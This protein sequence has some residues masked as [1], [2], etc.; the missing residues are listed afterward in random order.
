MGETHSR[1]ADADRDRA[2]L[3]PV[4][5]E[6]NEENEDN[7]NEDVTPDAVD[8]Q[9][10]DELEHEGIPNG[11]DVSG[12][13]LLPSEPDVE[14]DDIDAISMAESLPNLQRAATRLLDFFASSFSSPSRIAELA[15]QLANPNSSQT[16]K[17]Q[18]LN[19]H[20][21]S[22]R[23]YFGSD[24]YIPVERIAAIFP[25][26]DFSSKTWRVDGI[27]YK[28]NCAQLALEILTRIQMTPDALESLY[29]LEGQF[30]LP[31]VK[32][33][34][35]DILDGVGK[36]DLRRP[37]FDLALDIRTQWLKIRLVAEQDAK[38][39]PDTILNGVFFNESLESQSAA[40]TGS[41]LRGFNLAGFFQDEDGNLP[42]KYVE[43]VQE[44]IHEIRGCFKNGQVDFDALEERFPWE[45]FIFT[46]AKWIRSRNEELN[47]HL[48]QQ[49]SVD[50]IADELEKA[51]T[52]SN[53]EDAKEGAVPT[54]QEERAGQGRPG[55]LPA[56]DIKERRGPGSGK[57]FSDMNSI[58]A[59]TR[60]QQQLNPKN[61]STKASEFA[62]RLSKLVSN[63][64]GRPSLP[65]T[66]VSR[67]PA[68]RPRQQVSDSPGPGL[69]S[70]DIDEP[71][72]Q[73]SQQRR[74]TLDPPG[75]A[76]ATNQ[77]LSLPSQSALRGRQPG[78]F[79]DRQ[80][81]A[82]RVSPIDSQRLSSGGVS[83]SRK[84]TRDAFDALSEDDEDE[85]GEFES[86]SRRIDVQ[87]RRGQKPAQ[88][89][90][91]A[92]YDNAGND[93]EVS[94]ARRRQTTG[95]LVHRNEEQPAERAGPPAPHP[96]P[97]STPQR[98]PQTRRP[99]TKEED[100][101][102]ISLITKHGTSWAEIKSQDEN[103]EVPKLRNR[104]QGNLKDRARNLV[105]I[106]LK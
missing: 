21:A 44:R 33:L 30:P 3:A 104:D 22:Q 7:A 80:V 39:D 12:D 62:P 40:D 9:L 32:T 35:G 49:P 69:D 106:M 94:F 78:T 103:S 101:Q 34:A 59:F 87:D 89:A 6:D 2:D 100:E 99:W 37:T 105:M 28:S 54:S 43:D 19:T 48:E 63:T 77:R 60:L 41:R 70:G 90:K 97:Q 5:E 26:I 13:T 53:P 45:E 66:P 27:L 91:R 23:E 93:D 71:R 95:T 81:N 92:R 15:R 52:R 20:F 25:A 79:I 85:D 38:D 47:R 61:A 88:P 82:S 72:F 102:F 56:P 4:G 11:H 14:G 73:P 46:V 98:M 67:Q 18:Y 75:R 64:T 68:T 31:F 76:V 8:Q 17:L 74:R 36:S 57:S 50:E 55:L 84:R 65:V 42:D 58:M 24:V 10:N 1:I 16:K 83:S 86:D 29:S 96:A 51:L